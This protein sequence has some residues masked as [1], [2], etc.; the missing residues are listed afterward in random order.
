MSAENMATLVLELQELMDGL[1][2]EEWSCHRTVGGVWNKVSISLDHSGCFEQTPPVIAENIIS[3]LHA[4]FIAKCSPKNIAQLCNTIDHTLGTF[5]QLRRGL[6][7]FPD[8]EDAGLKELL[9]LFRS[10][11]SKEIDDLQRRE[12]DHCTPT[13]TQGQS[14]D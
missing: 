6:E 14:D 11:V 8:P 12:I 13:A 3:P 4:K 5:R 2:H 9:N 1:H 7:G 10:I